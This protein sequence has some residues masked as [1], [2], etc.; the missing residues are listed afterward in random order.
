[1][2]LEDGRILVRHVVED[3]HLK[4]LNR[5]LRLELNREAGRHELRG[6]HPKGAKISYH[7]QAP[8]ELWSKHRRE[9]PDIHA[10]LA[11][12]DY[13]QRELAAQKIAK[14]HPEWVV[15]APNMHRID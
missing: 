3:D 9:Y 1:M 4:A 7:F 11:S 8:P 13:M 12:G 14:S 6:V 10:A 5:R 2:K 15:T